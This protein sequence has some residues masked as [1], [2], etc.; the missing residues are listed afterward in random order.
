VHHFGKP[1]DDVRST[2]VNC[3]AR[4]GARPAS[5]ALS[6]IGDVLSRPSSGRGVSPRFGRSTSPGRVRGD[7]DEEWKPGGAWA[8]VR[9]GTGG[10]G[11]PC[12]VGRSP[13]SSR[14]FVLLWAYRTDRV[15]IVPLLQPPWNAPREKTVL[16]PAPTG[17]PS[18]PAGPVTMFAGCGLL[19]G[20]AG[21]LFVSP[22][23]TRIRSKACWREG[24]RV[25][26]VPTKLI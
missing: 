11:R 10:R 2:G 24:Y 1:H 15:V 5:R 4:L 14:C 17:P 20:S 7:A 9:R 12:F 25:G 8:P 6:R 3:D 13:A 18:I 22:A 26:A 19:P 23:R 16:I 21:W